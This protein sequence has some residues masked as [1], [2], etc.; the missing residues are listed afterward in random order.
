MPEAP[1]SEGGEAR[2]RFG[3]ILLGI[4]VVLV[5]LS[6]IF[7]ASTLRS[8]AAF[9]AYKRATL[10]DAT[11]IWEREAL[12]VDACVEHT[13]VWAMACPG[14]ESWCANEAPQL[15]RR[16]LEREDR[17][18][19]CATVGDAIAST[20]FGYHQCAALREEVDGK[21]AKRSHKK[22]C[23]AGYRAVAELCREAAAH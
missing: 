7:G 6:V 16:C 8:R 18:A 19:Y 1:T 10:T 23:A 11:P 5:L 20:S 13:V 12:T 22:F 4:G 2:P 9:D 15:T 21:Y 3:A 14:L 17:D